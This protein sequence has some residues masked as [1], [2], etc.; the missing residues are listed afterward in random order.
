MRPVHPRSHILQF[1][2]S[3]LAYQSRVDLPE[4]GPLQR[5]ELHQ[6]DHDEIRALRDRLLQLILDNEQQR[7]VARFRL[8]N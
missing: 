8:V 5:I 7:K 2:N 1:P 3:P 6:V 4:V